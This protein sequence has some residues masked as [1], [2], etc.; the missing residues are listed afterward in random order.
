MIKLVDIGHT[1]KIIGAYS[2][3]FVLDEEVKKLFW[4]D[5]DE[6]VRKILDTEKIFIGGDFNSYSRVNS[7]SF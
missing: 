1:L 3:R 2:L 6:V 5:F 7:S 4:K